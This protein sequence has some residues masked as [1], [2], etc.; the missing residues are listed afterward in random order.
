[1]LKS[2]PKDTLRRTN[3]QMANMTDA[4]ID[5]S[6][7]QLE[8]M[9]DNPEMVKMASDQMKNIREEDFEQMRKSFAP[10]AMPTAGTASSGGSENGTT[11]AANNNSNNT[12]PNLAGIDPSN[13]MSS[14]LSNPDQLNTIVK[15]MK[16]N[17]GMMK[18][19]LL[20]QMEGKGSEAQKEQFS[21]AIDS[22]VQ[23]DDDKLEKYLKVANGFQRVAK[24]VVITFDKMK[25]ILGVSTKT[26]VV[27]I[28]LVGL[29]SFVG[30]A[31]WW[32]LRKGSDDMMG[33][34]D[35]LLARSLEEV[36]VIAAEDEF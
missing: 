16:S 5:M 36:P 27:I 2:M 30:L 25:Q 26:L 1:M 18:S 7:A 14:L 33:V 31:R 13:M 21:K 17:P 35:D 11:T 24:P 20:S 28:N 23:M 34:E 22:F 4:Q 12:P 8:Q 29:A 15:T 3:P 19:M 10:G 32:M 6:I 9:A